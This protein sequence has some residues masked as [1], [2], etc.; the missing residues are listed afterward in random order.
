MLLCSTAAVAVRDRGLA[1]ITAILHGTV[2]QPAQLTSSA[3]QAVFLVRQPSALVSKSARQHP[4]GLVLWEQNRA[5]Q[6]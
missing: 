4:L 3:A 5:E 2:V 1:D 6:W